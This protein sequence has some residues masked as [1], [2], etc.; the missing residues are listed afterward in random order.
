MTPSELSRELREGH[1]ADLTRRRWIIGLSFVGAAMAQAVSLFQVGIVKHLPDLPLPRVNS[2]KVDA[3]DYA[4]KKLSMP[5]GPIMLGSYAVTAGLSAA[6][7][8]NRARERPV[9]PIA[10]AVKALYDAGNTL[11][12]ARE[13]WKE[14]RAFCWYCQVATLCSLATAALA[15][16]ELRTALRTLRSRRHVL[17]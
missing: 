12:L 8:M 5:D 17:A 4:Y 2:S 15:L 10:L 6:G 1:N 14:N 16:P 11:L 3:S 9:L 7:G 13:E